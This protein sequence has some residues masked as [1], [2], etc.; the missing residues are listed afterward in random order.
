MSQ[1]P[2]MPG[3]HIGI[4]GG[5]QLG[6]MMAL[7]GSHMGYRFTVLD[8]SEDAPC[9][10]VAN[11]HIQAAF[12]DKHAAS[13]LASKV[14]VITYEF[15]NIDAN[16]VEH[17]QQHALVPQGSE[18][19]HTTQHRWREKESL[20][21]AGVS[22]APYR[23]ITM[24]S[25]LKSA[26]EEL[27]TPS[28]LKTAS[29]GYD[30][31][32]QVVIHDADECEAAFSKLIVMN[33]QLVLEQFIDYEQEI[34]VIVARNKAG[35]CKVFPVAENIHVDNILHCTIVPARI[36]QEMTKKAE[37]VALRIA[38][39][40]QLC[41]L[42]AVEMFVGRDGEIYVN[43]LAPR[44]HNSGH[45]TMEACATSQ[46]EQHIRAV[47]NLKLGAT[48]LLTPVV[49]VNILGEHVDTVQDWMNKKESIPSGI[50]QKIHFYGKTEKKP[51][52]KMGHLNLLSEQADLA[53]QWIEESRI[54]TTQSKVY[55]QQ[56]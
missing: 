19:L 44:P 7:A 35:E 21:K 54:W 30:G 11:E 52:R 39:S 5:G 34:S 47:C 29:G 33:Q 32:G 28:V 25:Q 48:D 23:E 26:I 8:P 40:F 17:L 16:M 15:E 18:L 13:L 50:I 3:A 41:G 42:L 6:R 9:A 43:E 4:L 38:Q 51:K 1:L 12:D 10:Q 22:V 24:L 14:D 20:V 31:K 46:F 45:F 2:I 37:N 53:L 55:Q 27:G 56:N 49:M 36:S